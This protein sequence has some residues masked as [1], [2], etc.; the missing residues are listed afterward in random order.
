MAKSALA[1]KELLYV[2]FEFSVHA[3]KQTHKLETMKTIYFILN[4]FMVTQNK[5][6]QQS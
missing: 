3:F 1:S 6:E 4:L 5:T 2:T